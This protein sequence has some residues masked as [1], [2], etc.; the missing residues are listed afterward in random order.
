MPSRTIEQ[1][2]RFGATEESENLRNLQFC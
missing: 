1:L 2:E